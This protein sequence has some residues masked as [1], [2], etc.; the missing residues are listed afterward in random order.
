M[1]M[2]IYI[3]LSILF[4][5]GYLVLLIIYTRDW[6]KMPEFFPKN[7]VLDTIKV[8]VII[9]ARNE[10]ENIIPCL[11]SIQGQDYPIK[12]FEIILVDDHSEDETIG[13]A[14]QLQI[15]NLKIL[16]L[17]DCIKANDKVISFKK[18]AIEFAI[19]NSNGELLIFTDADCEVSKEWISEFV[20]AYQS[21]NA[22]MIA[23]PVVFW[24][25]ENFIQKF[26]SLD[27]LGMMLIT[28]A[29]IKGKYHYMCNG[30]NLAYSRKI[31]ES[32]S[33]FEGNDHFASGDDI[34]LMQKI[35]KRNPEDIFFLKSKKSIV[36]TK[37]QTDYRSFV[38]Q[39]L[40]WGTKSSAYEVLST[41][42]QLLLVWIFMMN[43]LIS[44]SMVVLNPKIGILMLT[45]QILIK[46]IAD[47]IL[48][49]SAVNYFERK[50][51]M[52]IFIPSVFTHWFY[53]LTI[54][55]LSIIKVKF[56]WKGRNYN[57]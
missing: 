35:A 22:Q 21:T 31:F 45:F 43:I 30:A 54:G 57:Q 26:Q 6:K 49:K 42:L 40:R 5:L 48:L 13:R 11:K 2:T 46:S 20:K 34:F 1:M 12:D 3:I 56:N 53:I 27:F 33:G 28:A 55:F 41:K 17:S 14:E 50:D 37:A 7:H 15:T 19:K 18:K 29:C 10:Q 9:I 32:V 44:I 16:R 25:E 8:S 39:R 51:L 4:A 47:Y 36:K 23:A 38:K 52:D 24:K